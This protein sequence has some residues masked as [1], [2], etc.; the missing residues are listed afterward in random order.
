MK[1]SSDGQA[2]S[3]QGDGNSGRLKGMTRFGLLR[4]AEDQ[5]GKR[6]ALLREPPKGP[7]F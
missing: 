7:R 2:A 6:Q 5:Q 3:L 1:G 4:L